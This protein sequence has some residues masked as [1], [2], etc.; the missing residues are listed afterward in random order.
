MLL[1]QAGLGEEGAF[2]V[3]QGDHL[4]AQL[5]DLLRRVLGDVAGAGNRH[6]LAVEAAADALE[7]LLGEIHAT[8]AGGLGANQAAAIGQAL[9]GQDRGEFVGQALVLAEEEADLAGADADITGR[10]VQVGTD[11]AVQLAHE[12]LAETHHFGVALALGVE[13]RAALAATHGQRGQGILEH[14]LEGEELQH[15][16][17]HGRMEAQ[18]ALVGTDG[19]AHL[20]AEATVDADPSLIVDPR[21]TEQDGTLRLDDPFDDAGLQVM[22]IGFQEGPQAAQHLFHGL[23]ELGLVG[24]TLLQAQQ[25]CVDGLRHVSHQFFFCEQFMARDSTN[26]DGTSIGQNDALL[27]LFGALDI[28]KRPN[29][30]TF[31]HLRR[32]FRTSSRRPV[33]PIHGA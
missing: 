6:P 2:G 13:V 24:I 16:Q 22:R 21:H 11:M 18:A 3:G 20:H 1:G 33:A 19:A 4:A 27:N 7:H 14:L 9:A 30:R 12:G 10:H 26:P 15:A 29:R 28:N 32:Y 17:V 8:E 31:L 5:H 23:M 25:E